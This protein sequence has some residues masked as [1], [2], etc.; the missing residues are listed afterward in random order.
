VF[1]ISP[2]QRCVLFGML[3]RCIFKRQ[4]FHHADA[5]FA[6]RACGM[7]WQARHSGKCTRSLN[8]AREIARIDCRQFFRLESASRGLGLPASAR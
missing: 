4:T 7:N 3:L 6:K 5:A 2:Q 8:S 1:E